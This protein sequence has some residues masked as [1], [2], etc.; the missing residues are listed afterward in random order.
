[1]AYATT[2]PPRL[3][4][5]SMGG[6]AQEWVYSSTDVS[7]AVRASTYFS[8]GSALGMRIGDW[9]KIVS[10]STAGAYV[11]HSIGVVSTVTASSA[12]TITTGTMESTA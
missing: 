7:T 9:V 5:P 8:N 1:M 12:A 2:N 10:L 11:S 6:G 4:T 3:M